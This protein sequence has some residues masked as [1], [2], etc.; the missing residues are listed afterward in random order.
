MINAK[1]S[2]SYD[3]L[4]LTISFLGHRVEW[5]KVECIPLPTLLVRK[6]VTVKHM[7]SKTYHNV[8]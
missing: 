7:P 5:H 6:S 3:N 1:L 2:P 4:Y 8:A